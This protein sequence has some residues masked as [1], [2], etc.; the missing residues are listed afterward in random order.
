MLSFTHRLL[1]RFGLLVVFALILVVAGCTSSQEVQE[2]PES[3]ASSQPSLS[4][5]VVDEGQM[6]VR[7]APSGTRA[8]VASGVQSVEARAVSPSGRR[9]AVAYRADSSRLAVFDTRERTLQR[10]HASA[11]P[12]TY[13]LAWHASDDT[14]AFGYYRPTGDGGRS[15][16][17]IRRAVPSGTV[18]DVGCSAAR[19]VLHW[20]SDATLAVRDD[21]NVYLVAADGCATQARIDVRQKHRLAV[22]P[23][24]QYLAYVEQD[25]RYVRSE[26]EYVPDSTLYV[27]DPDGQNATKLFGDERAMRHLRWS[28]T[29]PELAFDLVPEGSD[30][31]QIVTYDAAGERTQYLIPPETAPDADQVRPVWSPGG[32]YLAF[33]LRRETASGNSHT[34]AVR[35]AGETRTLGAATGPVWGWIGERTVVVPGPERYRVVTLTG[36]TRHTLPAA[37]TLVH[38]WRPRASM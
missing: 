5:L 29:A 30:R 35:T 14:L 15:A 34:A 8:T 12:V 33:T 28:P 26:G 6:Q 2:A 3:E 22:E 23:G 24:G 32:N 31:R 11:E 37:L 21:E 4:F 16:G 7:D 25:L 18:T 19:E 27:S 9:V 36:S 13:S 17:G 38:A 1:R 20:L 10:L